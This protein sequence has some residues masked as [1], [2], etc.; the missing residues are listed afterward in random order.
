MFLLQ[1]IP[2]LQSVSTMTTKMASDIAC[3]NVVGYR[4]GILA[5]FY[6]P[7]HDSHTNSHRHSEKKDDHVYITI[8]PQKCQS[9]MRAVISFKHRQ[10]ASE[11]SCKQLRELGR[12]LRA[13]WRVLKFLL[14]W[15]FGVTRQARK[16]TNL[17][18]TPYLSAWNSSMEL[19]V[20]NGVTKGF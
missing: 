20:T 2:C 18:N 16:S 15:L 8:S 9:S 6:S 5:I 17:G 12:T 14:K 10:N 19:A 11:A 4:R 3:L 13:N 7:F 1:S